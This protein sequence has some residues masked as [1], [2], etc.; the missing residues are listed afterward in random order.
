MF[1]SYE[2]WSLLQNFKINTLK[3]VTMFVVMLMSLFHV[4]HFPSY[5]T[6]L[7]SFT[8]TEAHFSLSLPT[9]LAG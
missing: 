5:L 1:M 6:F 4:F 2:M 9:S 8:L 3:R 7:L